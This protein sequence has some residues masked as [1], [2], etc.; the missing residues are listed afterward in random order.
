MHIC[1]QHQKVEMDSDNMLT[2]IPSIQNC[3]EEQRKIPVFLLLLLHAPTWM[4]YTGTLT[5][6]HHTQI[7]PHPTLT[8]IPYTH[9][10]ILSFEETWIKYESIVVS[11]ISQRT[12]N[13]VE[14]LFMQSI[15][16]TKIQTHIQTQYNTDYQR[17]QNRGNGEMLLREYSIEVMQDE[18]ISISNGGTYFKIK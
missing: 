17:Q 16:I 1:N 12:R 5:F 13:I 18:C 2:L 8:H 6:P 11:E 3:E 15:A 9:I 14:L 7:A 4:C 10:E